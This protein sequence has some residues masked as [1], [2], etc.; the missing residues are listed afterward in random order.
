[1][2]L[3]HAYFG[4]RSSWDF[5][6]R[7]K[8]RHGSP[9]AL[10][11][12]AATWDTPRAF[13]N[14]YK[15]ATGFPAPK[16]Y[17]MGA[18][19]R[20]IQFIVACFGRTRPRHG[21]PHAQSQEASYYSLPCPLVVRACAYSGV[22]WP[23]LS[24]ARARRPS[25]RKDNGTVYTHRPLRRKRETNKNTRAEA[26]GAQGEEHLGQKLSNEPS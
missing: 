25:A 20:K 3:P 13:R 5:P 8:R 19:T 24:R 17:D 10:K 22:S 15:S 9:H 2:G 14:I 11:N 23:L 21:R 16:T 12:P 7:Q 1:M 18:P 26:T 4:G 6:T